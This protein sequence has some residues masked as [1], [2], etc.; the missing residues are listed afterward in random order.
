MAK[1][2]VSVPE[3]HWSLREIE[4]GSVKEAF[5]KAR[6]GEGDDGATESELDRTLEPIERAWVAWE[7]GVENQGKP[8]YYFD[9][10]SIRVVVEK[11][12]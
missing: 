3:L 2:I 4:A 12:V 9:E 8:E 10:D 7:A 1:F 5:Q 11:I 6:N